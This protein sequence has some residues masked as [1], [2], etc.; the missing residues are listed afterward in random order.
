[1]VK[2]ISFFCQVTCSE[3][4]PTVSDEN[5]WKSEYLIILK[6]VRLFYKRLFDSFIGIFSLWKFGDGI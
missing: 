1:M 6:Q 3:V 4:K 2:N 5:D